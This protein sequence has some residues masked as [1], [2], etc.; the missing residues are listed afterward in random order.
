M[1]K[2]IQLA[3]CYFNDKDI[4]D[5]LSNSRFSERSL[6]KIAQATGII[7]NPKEAKSSVIEYLSRIP[8][9]WRGLQD[10]AKQLERPEREERRGA[11]RLKTSLTPEAVEK[12]IEQV[13][14]ARTVG[15]REEFKIEKVDGRL[16][17]RA[18]Y[19]EID[20]SKAKALQREEREYAVEIDPT[21][22]QAGIQFTHNPKA[23]EFVSDLIKILRPTPEA[24]IER[25]I[26]LGAI[27]DA[28]L[29]TEFFLKLRRLMPGFRQLDVVDLKVDRRLE[30]LVKPNP[31]DEDDED[32]DEK[33]EAEVKSMVKSA[34]LQGHGLL[35][36]ELYQKMREMGYFVYRMQW[37]SIET[38]GAGRLMEFEAG[39]E[40]PVLAKSFHYDLKKVVPGEHDKSSGLTQFEV[41]SRERDRVRRILVDAA[42]NALE[43]I[44]TELKSD[45]T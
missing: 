27:K 34:A 7:F 28:A 6:M 21:S 4:S 8:F 24:E 31:S 10:L 43:E 44:R 11:T 5:V 18:K 30:E 22:T 39:F 38:E 36:T 15:N 25:P 26:D 19:I 45:E 17:V 23:R 14:A 3:R 41:T 37:S 13:K 16:I 33:A 42:Y 9:D 29:R 2:H 35:T 40:D 1:A 20:Y 12:A 32:V